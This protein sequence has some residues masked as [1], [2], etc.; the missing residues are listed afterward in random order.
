MDEDLLSHCVG[1]NR[2][3]VLLGAC[4]EIEVGVSAEAEVEVERCGTRGFEQLQ[5]D[6][7]GDDREDE[8]EDGDRG[9]VGISG[10][11][12]KEGAGVTAREGGT[13]L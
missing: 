4:P 6:S 12:S 2:R 1:W 13:L 3:E 9:I 10:R 8:G 5:G 7:L 11:R